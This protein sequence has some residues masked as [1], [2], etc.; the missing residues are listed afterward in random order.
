MDLLGRKMSTSD[1]GASGEVF[2]PR[3]IELALLFDAVFGCVALDEAR[4]RQRLFSGDTTAE[5]LLLDERRAEVKPF[6]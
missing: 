2:T 4:V 3:E 5:E 6:F 1:D